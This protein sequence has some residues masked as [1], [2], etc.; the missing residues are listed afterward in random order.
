[1]KKVLALMIAAAFVLTMYV[2]A[3]AENPD[4]DLYGHA[5][6]NTFWT[7][8]S[9]ER[10]DNADTTQLDH[11]LQGNARIGATVDHGAIGGGFEYGSG[12]NVRKLYGTVDMGQGELKIG[13]DYAPYGAGAFISTQAYGD[14]ANMLQFVGYTGRKPMVQY[15]VDNFKI[16]LVEPQKNDLQGDSPDQ[17]VVLPQL[18]ASYDLAIQDNVN[19]NMAGAY[20]TYELKDDTEG[21]DGE[22][23]D[24][25]GLST[26]IRLTAMDP[27]YVNVGGYYGQNVGNFGQSY[28][29]NTTALNDNDSIYFNGLA[30]LD[31]DSIEDTDSYGA[32]LALGTTVNNIGLE[33]GVGYLES[34]ND[35]WEK[36]NELMAYYGQANIPLTANGNAFIVP[37][38]GYYDYGDEYDND[39]GDEMGDEL[40]AG[41]KWQVNF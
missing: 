17:E 35:A 21:W 40:Y 9:D 2:P 30:E 29:T 15:S 25:W 13:Q 34:D 5:R 16:A 4:W 19:I 41:L 32:L 26:N 12:V 20:Q 24:A 3:S 27:F 14:D 36:E 18:Q 7:D 28:A 22:N 31:G 10:P 38:V 23:L 37:E 6:V 1:M 39:S 33:A 8:Y 11:D